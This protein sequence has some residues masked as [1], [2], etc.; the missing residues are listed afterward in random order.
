MTA[1]PPVVPAPHPFRVDGLDEHFVVH[2]GRVEATIPLLFTSNLGPTT[3]RV[4]LTYQACT[5]T[6]CLP[7]A[8]VQ[9]SLPLEGLDLIRD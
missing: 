8:K 3:V 7:P 1:E 2:E 6:I 9:V 5:E 4:H